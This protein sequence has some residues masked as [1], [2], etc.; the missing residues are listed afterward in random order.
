MHDNRVGIWIDSATNVEIDGCNI[1]D[2]TARGL[3]VAGVQPRHH[4]SQHGEQRQR[5]R[6]GECFGDADG[7][8]VEETA[9]DVEFID[10]VARNNA[11]DGFDIQGDNVR[12]LRTVVRDNGCTGIK[13]GQNGR[14]ENTLVTGNSLGIAT[15]SYFN[16]TTTVEI[17]NSTIADN[18][19]QQLYLKQ[20]VGTPPEHYNV[21]VHNVIA[22]GAGKAIEAGTAVVLTEHH[23]LLFRD[24]T[25]NPVIVQALESGGD[26]RYSGQDINAGVW[27]ADSGQ[28][29]GTWAISP[30]FADPERLS[31][32]GGQRC[33]RQRGPER[34]PWRKTSRVRRGRR[35]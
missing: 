2:N 25:T 35:A 22:F 33:G 4:G 23:N 6:L 32:G 29:T 34:L 10:C 19:G 21:V 14:I 7:F 28:G 12:V 24:D 3:R 8:T 17:V 18:A 9:S 13:M 5:R 26:R 20:P 31:R 30:D 27:T 16:T 11:E 1:H 15:T